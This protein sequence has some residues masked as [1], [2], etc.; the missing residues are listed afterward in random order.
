MTRFSDNTIPY[1]AWDR[2]I[3]AGEIKRR[4]GSGL[5]QDNKSLVSWILREA[6]FDDVWQ[7]LTPESVAEY[8]PLITSQLGR[9]KEFWTYIFRTW[10]ELGKI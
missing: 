6:A 3:T 4:L 10:H 8:L 1:F 7:F 5:L 9:K 2:A